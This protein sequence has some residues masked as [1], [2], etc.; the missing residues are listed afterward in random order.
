MMA[1]GV[2]P[3]ILGILLVLFHVPESPRFL[4]YQGKMDGV[5]KFCR[6]VADTN[7]AKDKLLN[8]G[9]VQPLDPTRFR[10]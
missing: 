3:N 5:Q 8:D 4:L 6:R 9:A 7:G 1:A 10:T 2:I